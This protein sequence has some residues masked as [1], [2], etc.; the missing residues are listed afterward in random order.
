[1]KI[2]VKIT[3]LERLRRRWN[4]APDKVKKMTQDAL[5]KSGYRVE[6]E[7]KL[8]VSGRMV[9]VQTG[10]LRSSISLSSSLAL[11]AEPHVVISP[12]VFYAKFLHFGTRYIK[13]RPFMTKAYSSVKNQIRR[14]MQG[15][16]KKVIKELK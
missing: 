4:S 7:A 8:N 3:G 13:A 16:L 10:R 14:D 11:R 2:D 6:R 15:L 9:N 5:M 12:H 1:M